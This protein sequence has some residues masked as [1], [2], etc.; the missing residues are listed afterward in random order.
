MSDLDGVLHT[1][2]VQYIL[3]CDGRFSFQKCHQAL[4]GT[5]GIEA[6]GGIGL[7]PRIQGR[8]MLV[9]IIEARDD[10]GAFKINDLGAG[11]IYFSMVRSLPAA[12]MRPSFTARAEVLE[13]LPDNVMIFPFFSTRLAF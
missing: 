12:R 9:N 11:E 5:Y 2:L 4:H 10:G 8:G 1:R 3:G 6:E 13:P 7:I